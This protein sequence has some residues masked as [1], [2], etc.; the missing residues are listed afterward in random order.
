[1]LN[2]SAG[3]VILVIHWKGGVHTDLRL[4]RR[5]R[6]VPTKKCVKRETV[7]LIDLELPKARRA[8]ASGVEHEPFRSSFHQCAG[9]K[10]VR[11]RS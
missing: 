4:P 3:E 7:E 11:T 5:R 6:G 2:P 1:M 10:P 9:A 8:G